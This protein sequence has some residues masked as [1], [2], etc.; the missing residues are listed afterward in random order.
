ML[1]ALA[2][3]AAGFAVIW[4]STLGGS[5]TPTGVE[6]CSAGSDGLVEALARTLR[7]GSKLGDVRVVRSPAYPQVYFAAAPVDS[8]VVLW[9]TTDEDGGRVYAADSL[10]QSVS[11][12]ARGPFSRVDAG[13]REAVACAKATVR[14][15]NAP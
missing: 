6:G 5:S 4:A 15:E 14:G 8:V 1:F 11:T 10:T 7:T 12:A 3:V 9:A 2:V 13:A